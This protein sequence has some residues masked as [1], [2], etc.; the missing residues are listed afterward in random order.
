MRIDGFEWHEAIV[1]KIEKK[2]S[3]TIEEAEEVFDNNIKV[4][5]RGDRYVAL[6]VTS[7]GRYLFVVFAYENWIVRFITVREMTKS[8]RKRYQ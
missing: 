3:V 6:G 8:E 5:N 2:H 7:S 4:F 1:E